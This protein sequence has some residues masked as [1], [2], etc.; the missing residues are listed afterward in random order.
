MSNIDYTD[1]HAKKYLIIRLVIILINFVIM[2]RLIKRLWLDV[3]DMYNCDE[4]GIVKVR[5]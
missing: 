3:Q 1:N 2:T 4:N 5:Y